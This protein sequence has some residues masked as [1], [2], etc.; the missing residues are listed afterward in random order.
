MSA[1]NKKETDNLSLMYE[2][3]K[4]RDASDKVRG[5]LFQDYIAIKC[6]LQDGVE[7]VCSEYLE[8]VDVF[9]EDSYGPPGLDQANH[10]VTS[11]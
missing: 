5:F 8:D 1:I 6:L 4:T 7:Y 10:I 3:D 9:F 11:A 2:G